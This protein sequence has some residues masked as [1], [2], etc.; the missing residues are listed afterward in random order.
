MGGEP[1]ESRVVESIPDREPPPAWRWPPLP[2]PLSLRWRGRKK[3]EKEPAGT[4]AKTVRPRT[5]ASRDGNDG[6]KPSVTA[7]LNLRSPASLRSGRFSPVVYDSREPAS[8]TYAP[9]REFEAVDML[10]QLEM[11]GESSCPLEK[12]AALGGVGFY[13]WLRGRARRSGFWICRGSGTQEQRHVAGHR[14]LE[15]RVRGRSSRTFLVRQI[16]WIGGP[17]AR[18][19]GRGAPG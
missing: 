11:A 9:Y 7:E 15:R 5:I 10:P 4:D 19:G 14:D 16:L 17:P 6:R 8:S 12:A 1:S 18:P 3:A 13:L 2:L